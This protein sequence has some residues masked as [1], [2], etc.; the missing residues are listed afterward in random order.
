VEICIPNPQKYCFGLRILIP[1]ISLQIRVSSAFQYEVGWLDLPLGCSTDDDITWSWDPS[2][3]QDHSWPSAQPTLHLAVISELKASLSCG[4]L[5]DH[6]II[7]PE[8]NIALK[9]G[10][11]DNS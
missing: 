9:I 7:F 10:P 2:L 11:S 3:S 4:F 8:L 5:P 1:E 6:F